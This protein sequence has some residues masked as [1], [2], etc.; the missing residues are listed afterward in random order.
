MYTYICLKI[1]LKRN[2]IIFTSYKA[3]SGLSNFRVFTR[4]QVYEQTIARHFLLE[5]FF[6]SWY[7]DFSMLHSGLHTHVLPLVRAINDNSANDIF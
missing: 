5:H 7:R 4:A 1:Y 2:Y 3:V 6:R